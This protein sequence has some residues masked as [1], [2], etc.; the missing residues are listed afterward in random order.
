[1]VHIRHSERASLLVGFVG[2]LL[3][4]MQVVFQRGHDLS[5]DNLHSLVFSL[6]FVL[7]CSLANAKAYFLPPK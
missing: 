2:E 6:M 3:P 1:M 7:A 5:L 4:T